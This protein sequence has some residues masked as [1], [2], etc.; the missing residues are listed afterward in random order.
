[1]RVA[2]VDNGG[3]FTHL[4][5]RAFR[6]LGVEHELVDNQAEPE[7]VVERHDAVVLSG[8]PRIEDV[9]RSPDYLSF[10]VPVLGICLGHQLIAREL[11]GEVEAG[12]HG[13]YAD[14]EIEVV[15]PG[16][17]FDGVPA[18]FRA[19]ASH[20]DEV[21]ELPEGFRTTA[22][23]DVCEIEAM[24]HVDRAIYGVQ[25]HPE[26]SHTEHGLDV[27]RNYVEIAERHAGGP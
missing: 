21:V 1:M 7:D 6:D 9:G 27:L 18:E 12:D 20:A 4:E 15:E 26:V 10:D 13:G 25:F 17:L 2:V 22:R 19:W 23:S 14:V 24:E 3:Q 8:G 11:G 5:G 16:G